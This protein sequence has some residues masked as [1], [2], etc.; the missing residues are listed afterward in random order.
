MSHAKGIYRQG[1]WNGA[2]LL[3]APFGRLADTVL[4]ALLR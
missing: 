3:R 4:R 2:N 1:R